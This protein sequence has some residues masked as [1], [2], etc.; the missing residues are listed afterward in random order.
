MRPLLTLT[1]LSTLTAANRTPV[2]AVETKPHP[3]T[4]PGL[5]KA[6]LC[7][8]YPV[9]ED[10]D[11]KTGRKIGLNIVILPSS[12]AAPAK[13]SPNPRSAMH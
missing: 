10:R 12:A 11:H 2:P 7:A 9:W 5:S 4:I 6:A 3:C 13:V 1:L 8:T